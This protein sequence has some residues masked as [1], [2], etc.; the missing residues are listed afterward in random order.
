M[1]SACGGSRDGTEQPPSQQVAVPLVLVVERPV[2]DFPES[3]VDQIAGAREAGGF[4]GHRFQ[5]LTVPHPTRSR[6]TAHEQAL[7]A[8]L[9]HG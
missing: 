2:R 3:G 6:A 5:A 7:R 8:M 9:G 1:P 4:P